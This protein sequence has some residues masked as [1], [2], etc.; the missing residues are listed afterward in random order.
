MGTFPINLPR[1]PDRCRMLMTS[2][3]RV[4]SSLAMRS[5]LVVAALSAR[6][7]SA[8]NW[9]QF[10]GP[11][12]QGRSE[13][14]GLAL[15][16]S[17]T[18]NVAWKTPIPGKGWSSPV[19]LGNDIWMT[20]A[21]DGGK[22]LQAICVDLESGSIKH[23]I[24]VF[25]PDDPVPIN[26]K[27]S[28]ASPTPVVEPGRVYVH[29]GAMGTACLDATTGDILWRNNE[30]A[31][32]HK[33]GPGSS[34]ILFENFLI[35][36]CDGQDKQ[37]VVALH[38][39]D[40]STAWRTDRSAPFREK[41]DFRKAYATPILIAVNGQEQLL[42]P[43]ADQ[44]QSYD[45]RTG[46]ELWQVRYKGFSNVPLPLFVD[47]MIY[48]CTGYTVPELWAIRPDGSGNVTDTHIVWKFKRQVSS[49][50]SPVFVDGRIY[51]AGDRGVAT[52]VDAK[53]GALVWQ[54]R[55]GDN[56]TASPLYADGRIYF[57]SEGGKVTVVEPG[58]KY[59]VLATNQ[60]DGR[61]MASPAISGDS[62]ILRT[63]THL[64]RIRGSAATAAAGN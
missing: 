30:H 11:N 32:D 39:Q 28:H 4:L 59:K 34:P 27:N 22:S 49:N 51:M 6:L 15:T 16:W 55:L 62:L 29:F 20:T 50:P 53:D 60:L 47:G 63:D 56:Y 35:F 64:Y 26:E 25:T 33:E 38:K 61:F 18:E 23:D 3:P 14:R 44:V 48:L 43:G 21:L 5:V 57:A 52:C 58:A 36:N 42:S 24:E 1:L 10:R 19:I 12:G 46:R 40:G 2:S 37:Y 13:A 7:A 45:P 41:I 31:I 8:E 54:E 17:E 9:W